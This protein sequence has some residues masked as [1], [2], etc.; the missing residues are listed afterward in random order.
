MK[1]LNTYI[2]E[3]LKIN[4]EVKITKSLI[5]M[6]NLI[7]YMFNFIDE[8]EKDNKNLATNGDVNILIQEIY[9]WV[10]KNNVNNV[11]FYTNDINNL[12]KRGFPKKIIDNYFSFDD[13]NK[14]N[15]EYL[16]YIKTHYDETFLNELDNI[17]LRGYDKGL[18]CF[19]PVKN[20]FIFV[21]NKSI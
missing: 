4:K 17:Q 16:E 10:K 11:E 21:L 6:S 19:N 3:K 18:L 9:N 7:S 8:N 12:K 2:I 5:E 14:V 1:Q 13:N 15:N 20:I